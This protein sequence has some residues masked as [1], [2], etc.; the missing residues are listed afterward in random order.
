MFQTTFCFCFIWFFLSS[1]LHKA[2]HHIQ[3]IHCLNIWIRYVFI[4]SNNNNIISYRAI[5][6]LRVLI[7]FNFPQAIQWI[8]KTKYLTH[9]CYFNS[10][11]FPSNLFPMNKLKKKKIANNN[12]FSK[13]NTET[14]LSVCHS[15]CISTPILIVYMKLTFTIQ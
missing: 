3:S 4:S 11:F 12:R 14:Y 2:R 13:N 6:L 9:L 5:E 7:V 10:S 8:W 15:F 1:N